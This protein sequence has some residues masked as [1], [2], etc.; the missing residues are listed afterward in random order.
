MYKPNQ[1]FVYMLFSV[2]FLI[3]LIYPLDT[4]QFFEISLSKS[5]VILLLGVFLLSLT[6]FTKNKFTFIDAGFLLITTMYI[7]LSFYYLLYLSS[8]III[9]LLF[10]LFFFWFTFYVAYFFINYLYNYYLL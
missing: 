3:G 1:I 8:A 10:F 2:L 5:D 6:V 4:I 9:F 7:V